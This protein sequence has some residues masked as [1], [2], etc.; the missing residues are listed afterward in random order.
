MNLSVAFS[1]NLPNNDNLL[2]K[3]AIFSFPSLG[4]ISTLLLEVTQT[5]PTIISLRWSPVEDASFYNLLIWKPG[6]SKDNQQLTVFE[7]SIT[8]SD[9]SPN[10]AYCFSVLAVTAEKS[11]P[12]SEPVCLQTDQLMT[13]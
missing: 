12:E 3:S 7:E 8:L 6:G 2:V 5:S 13:Q 9:L 11:G 4:N 1:L 10:S